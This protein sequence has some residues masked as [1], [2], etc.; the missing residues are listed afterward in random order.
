MDSDRDSDGSEWESDEEYVTPVRD[1]SLPS[2][3]AVMKQG[4]DTEEEEEDSG[5]IR[6]RLR[7]YYY[8]KRKAEEDSDEEREIKKRFAPTEDLGKMFERAICRAYD[9]PYQ[10]KYKYGTPPP[11]LKER[12]KRLK[13]HF[14]VECRHTA[15]RGSRYDFTSDTG[16]L[17][18][19]TSKQ[20][21][22]KVAPQVL[23]QTTLNRFR[24]IFG[25]DEEVDVKR[26]IQ[27]NILSILPMLEEYTFD[28][29]NVYY[30]EPRDLIQH[31]RRARPINWD[32]HKYEW[33]RGY[34]EWNN[35]S[36]LKIDGTPLLEVQI[37]SK[38]RKNLAIR[39][40][41]DNL[42]RLFKDN[43]RISVIE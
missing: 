37:H 33:T 1:R 2:L 29:D 19:K 6:K 17:S 39:W 20:R 21:V 22:G 28:S 10:G 5:D 24:I 34:Q 25:I 42:L 9:I 15:D 16:Y 12:L 4:G 18:A 27:E 40:Y 23:G 7:F 35:S 14:G 36:T 11:K 8:K 32:E 31:I 13:D 38:N 26:Y 43:F 3:P 41:Y 30:N